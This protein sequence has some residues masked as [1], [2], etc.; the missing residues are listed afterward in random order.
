MGVEQHTVVIVTSWDRQQ[1][2]EAAWCAENRMGGLATRIVESSVN[3]LGSFFIAPCGSRLGWEVEQTHTAL[4]A[5]YVIDVKRRWP[6]VTIKIVSFGD[7]GDTFLP[8][9][10]GPK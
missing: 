7:L 5:Q 3:Q 10:E 8:V 4:V 1:L 6:N 2:R 9:P